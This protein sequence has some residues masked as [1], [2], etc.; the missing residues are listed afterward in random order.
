MFVCVFP[1]SPL[2][3]LPLCRYTYKQ[4]EWGV[5]GPIH[6]GLCILVLIFSIV[7]KIKYHDWTLT[8]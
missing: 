8:I 2:P 7:A 4:V 6:V 3:H 5:V 1:H